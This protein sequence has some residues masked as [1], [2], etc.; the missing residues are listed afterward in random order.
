VRPLSGSFDD[1]FAAFDESRSDFLRRVIAA[2]KTSRIWTTLNPDD[3]AA[4]LGEERSR[5]VAALG[6]LE[7]RGLVE[8]KAADARQRY[9]LLARPDSVD[10]LLVRLAERFD[11]RELAETE[12]IQRVVDLVTH[13]GCQVKR[14]GRLLRR[15]AR[16][17]VRA[18]QLLPDRGGAAAA[19]G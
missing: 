14:A 15:G 11:R 13:E 1:V 9:T 8:L 4:E 18:L 2:G 3:A 7:E 19:G 17:A 10:D 5:I 16:G 6:H 12:R